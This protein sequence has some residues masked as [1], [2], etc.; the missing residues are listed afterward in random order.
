MNQKQI[1]KLAYAALLLALGLVLPQIFHLFGQRAGQ[2]F[3]PMHIPVLVAGF[4]LGPLYGGIVGAAT[5]L[6]SFAVTGMPPMPL[7]W[8]MTIELLVYGVC[9]GLFGKKMPI[10]LALP[11]TQI[12]GRIVE[13][14]LLLA[15]NHLLRVNGVPSASIVVSAIAA[16][17]V[18]IAL[19]WILV[20]LLVKMLRRK[21]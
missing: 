11:L 15:L 9:G 1:K 4:V 20:P 13:A 12:L 5:P 14:G 21:S 10:W 3:L 2:L 6:L 16:G 8:F 18:G 7:L 19:Q 17:V